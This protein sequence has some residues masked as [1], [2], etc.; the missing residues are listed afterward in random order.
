MKVLLRKNVSHLGTIG[1]VVEVKPGYARNYLIPQGLATQPTEANVK[2]V[3]AAKQQYLEELARIRTELEA[4]AKVVDGTEIEIQA[5]ANEEG[6]LYGSIG[7]AQIVAE[8]A[9]GNVFIEAEYVVLD[10]PVRQ[11]GRFQIPLRFE[12]GI[13]ASVTLWV[14]PIG[15][16][17]EDVASAIAAQE[18]EARAEAEKAEAAAKA[19]AEEAESEAEEEQ[20]ETEKAEEE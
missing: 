20:A 6:H 11:I 7:P 13:E 18:A 12:E 2:A 17:R 19:A 3:E 5:R 8:L 10:H 1:E 15:G 4:K 14:I 9:S 16:T